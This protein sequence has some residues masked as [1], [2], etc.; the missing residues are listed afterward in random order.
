MLT[1]HIHTAPAPTPDMN[2]LTEAFYHTV[3][4][5]WEHIGIYLHL[6][7]AGLKTIAAEHQHDSHKCLIGMLGVW[8]KRVDPPPP[9]L[10]SLRLWSFWGRTICSKKDTAHK[11]IKF[12]CAFSRACMITAFDV[13]CLIIT[14]MIVKL[15]QRRAKLLENDRHYKWGLHSCIVFVH[16]L[17]FFIQYCGVA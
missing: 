10:P 7:M 9:G 8:L 14:H 16:F 5:K 4:D 12:D 1:N 2:D 17:S 3:A 13:V 15:H 11:F 6:P